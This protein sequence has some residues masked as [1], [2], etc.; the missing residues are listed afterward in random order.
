VVERLV[1]CSPIILCRQEALDP[2]TVNIYLNRTTEM[3]PNKEQDKSRD[4]NKKLQQTHTIQPYIGNA[5]QEKHC[6]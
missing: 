2:S 6:E 3:I 1:R 4:M 5:R